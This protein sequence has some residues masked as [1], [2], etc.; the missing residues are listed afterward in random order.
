MAGTAALFFSADDGAS[1]AV[2]FG[3]ATGQRLG[4]DDPGRGHRFG[5][6]LLH[7]PWSLSCL[8]Q[9]GFSSS[10]SNRRSF[11]GI[12]LWKSNG[13]A[14]GTADDRGNIDPRPLRASSTPLEFVEMGGVYLL[15]HRRRWRDRSRDVEAATGTACR[16]KWRGE[17][18]SF[19]VSFHRVRRLSDLT[20]VGYR[21]L[22]RRRGRAD[23]QA[24]C[25]GVAGRRQ[26]HHAGQ[27]HPSRR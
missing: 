15:L 8:R 3:R 19:Q 16:N 9:H 1:A 14:S 27:G 20:M 18:H 7:S 24:S 13:T 11:S 4:D 26:Q 10:L 23:G 22:L 25:A 12:E 5:R 17:R 6:R 21:A 2:S